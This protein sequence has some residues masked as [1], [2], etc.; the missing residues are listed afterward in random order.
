M[1]GAVSVAKVKLWMLD[2]SALLEVFSFTSMNNN[3]KLR[4]FSVDLQHQKLFPE[5]KLFPIS[6]C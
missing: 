3:K 5:L 4:F 2:E 1:D 6:Q